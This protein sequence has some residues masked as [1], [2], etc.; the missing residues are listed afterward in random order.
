M[1]RILLCFF[2]LLLCAAPALADIEISEVMAS[3]GVYVNGE[4]YD[5]VELHNTGKKTV[6]LSGCYLS[7]SKKKPTKWA[8]PKNTTVKAGAYILVYCTG[9]DMDA[10]KNGDGHP[11]AGYLSLPAPAA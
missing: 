3:N 11:N 2:F 7:D 4:A 1:K 6:D 10:G 5:W 8:F 9:E